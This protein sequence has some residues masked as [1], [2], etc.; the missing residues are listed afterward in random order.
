MGASARAVLALLTATL[1][2]LTGQSTATAHA[3]LVATFP[4][5]GETLS[6]VPDQVVLEF[7]TPVV[8]EQS[9]VL[10]R[11]P[12][13]RTHP[14]RTM[15]STAGEVLVTLLEPG[16]PDGGWTVVYEAVST[17][18]H[19]LTGTVPFSVG[20]AGLTAAGRAD[21]DRLGWLLPLLGVVLVIGFSSVVRA[22]PGAG[23][24]S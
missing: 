4:D 22:L 5:A 6:S 14:A 2:C 20:S 16:G 7:A 18:G 24:D 15:G 1:F 9:R 19:T 8:A 21:T 12:G 11:E 10:V 3:E 13:G 17:D 23:A